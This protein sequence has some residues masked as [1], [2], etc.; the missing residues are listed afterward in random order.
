MSEP[1][2][3]RSWSIVLT[4]VATLWVLEDLSRP[5]VFGFSTFCFAPLI[6]LLLLSNYLFHLARQ[7]VN[8]G[9]PEE[10]GLP[11]AD[12]WR[13]F[14]LPLAF[15]AILSTWTYPW[16]A[17]LRFSLSRDAFE[18]KVAEIHRTGEDQGPQRVGLYFVERI[19]THG[20]GYVGFVTGSGLIDP[21]GL[22]HDPSRPPSSRC[23]I[24]L[25]GNWY[26]TEW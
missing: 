26:A 15:G 24:H 25:V 11:P 19:F 17:I 12:L 7:S 5:L 13:W 22:A 20:N 14:V 18:R 4:I 23:N 6:G 3:P 2:G 10:D 1:H 8:G 16:P 9:E 21:A